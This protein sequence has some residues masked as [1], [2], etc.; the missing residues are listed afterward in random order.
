MANME[1]EK[2]K[3]I[4]NEGTSE[5]HSVWEVNIEVCIYIFMFMGRETERE[6][7]RTWE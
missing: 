2:I 1:R 3:C 4:G 5:T 6:C 7:E